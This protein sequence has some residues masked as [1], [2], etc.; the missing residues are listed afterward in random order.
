MTA[1]PSN[2]TPPERIDTEEQ[3]DEVMTRPGPELIREVS[4]LPSPLL[5]LGAAGK[6]GPSL[7]VRVRRAAEAAGANLEVVAIS[8]FSSAG[9]REWLESRGVRTLSCDL[10][11]RS[12]V[13]QLPNSPNVIYLVGLKFGTSQNPSMTWAV[14]TLVPSFVAERF[15]QARIVALSTGNVYSLTSLSKGGSVETDPLTP[16]GE[17]ANAAV[18]RER[19]FEYYSRKNGTPVVL[20]RLN[21]AVDLRYGVLLEIAQKVW[22]RR[23]VDVTMGYFNCIWQGDANEMIVRSLRLAESP[24]AAFN[25]T[26]PEILS[27]REVAQGF[28]ELMER[29]AQ[30]TGVATE[31]A[32][33]SNA[34]RLCGILGQPATAVDTVMRW[35][36]HWVKQGSRTLGKP[37][38]FEV[39]DGGY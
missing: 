11:E 25:L 8:R 2:T 36:A 27:V 4:T 31:T 12:A 24:T 39:R 35:T 34:S 15:A 3:L 32:L 19:L 1:A 22:A 18:A 16:L 38:H 37:T 29:P 17:Y 20:L 7:A 13:T 30:A 5:I 33:L 28:G 9:T 23:P 26:G 6:M 10:L 21:Y 14:N